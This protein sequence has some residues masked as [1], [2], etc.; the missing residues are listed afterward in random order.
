MTGLD[1]WLRQATRGLSKDSSAQVRTEIH[2]HYESAREAA[3]NNGAAAQEADRSALAA[4]GDAATANRQY[5]RV[6]L[7]SSE[8]RMLR[9]G[10]WEAQAVCSRS[11]VKWLLA[12]VPVAAL[13]AA[14][15]LYLAG[16]GLIARVVVAGAVMMGLLFTAPYLPVYTTS[17]SRVFRGVK[18]VAMMCALVLAFGPDALKYFWLLTACVWQFAWVEWTRNSIRRKLPVSRWPR[19]LYL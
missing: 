17:R 7:T 19:Q 5:R 15:A 4:L 18:W 3:I 6:L 8:A 1:S 10:N 16:E 12:A 9:E 13:W 11:L 14:A 2:E